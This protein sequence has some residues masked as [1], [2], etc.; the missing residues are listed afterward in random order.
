MRAGLVTLED[1]VEELV[2]EIVDEFDR[3][4]PLLEPL[5]GG[6][7]QGAAVGRSRYL[8]RQ[9]RRHALVRVISR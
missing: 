7:V 5:A 8:I 3:P 9:P 6:E 1:L 2:G 4:E